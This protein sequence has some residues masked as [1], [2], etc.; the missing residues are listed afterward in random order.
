MLPAALA[1][2]EPGTWGGASTLDAAVDECS[3]ELIGVEGLVFSSQNSA[4]L[5]ARYPL[6]ALVGYDPDASFIS[7]HFAQVLRVNQ[8]YSEVLV[9]HSAV[10]RIRVSRVRSHLLSQVA[11]DPAQIEVSDERIRRDDQVIDAD[12]LR[13]V[14]IVVPYVPVTWVALA[15]RA[16]DARR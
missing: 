10:R 3:H 9:D 15:W 16:D 1:A 5:G 4:S 13:D 11:V 14:L 6:H 7:E 8:R 2:R 12:R